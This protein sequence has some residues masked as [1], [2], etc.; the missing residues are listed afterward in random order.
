[1]L[2]TTHEY[3]AVVVGSGPNGLAAAINLARNGQSVL[4]LEAAEQPGGGTRTMELTLPGFLHD[5]CSAIHPLALASPFFRTLPLGEHGLSWIEPPVQLAHPFDD[6]TAAVLMRSVEQTACSLGTDADAYRNVMQPYLDQAE[7]LFAS[8]LGPFRL[9]R[10][11]VLLGRFG[12]VGLQSAVGFSRRHFSGK[13]APAIFAGM[14]AH[15]LVPLESTTTAAYGLFLAVLG[16]AVGWPIAAGGSMRIADALVSLLN[17]L[18]GEILTDHRVESLDDLPDSRA[19]VFDLTPRQILTITG[20]RFP[21]R[22]RRQLQHFRYGPGVFK[23]DYALDGPVPWRADACRRAGTVHL[24]GTLEEIARSEHAVGQGR[25]PEHPF[26][27]TAQQSLF[28]PARAPEGKQTF[29]AY[30]HV[31]N[32]SNVDMTDRIE[33]QIERFAPG[34]RDRVLARHV[35][36]PQ[37]LEQY[38]S[39]DV[40]G[41]INGGLQDIRQLFTRPA[42]RINPYTTPDP[43]LFIGSSSTPPGGGVHGMGGYY[44]TQT[45][46]R[47]DR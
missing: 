17:A 38:N 32:G 12:L 35:I 21:K 16:H 19:V 9:P 40:G 15:A 28:D 46:I 18:G 26:V 2:M 42:P 13:Q 14:A 10:H 20:D 45:L 8:I 47:R 6:G 24:G 23:I 29:W 37:W 27:L 33:A 34:F 22:Y 41:D 4:V 5:V 43:R 36:T 31:P 3:D 7:A 44:A 11:P 30:C 1:M 25:H 39:N